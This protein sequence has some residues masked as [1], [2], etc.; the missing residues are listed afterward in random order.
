[1]FPVSKT[2]IEANISREAHHGKFEFRRIQEARSTS[3]RQG[4]AE[5]ETRAR[6]DV[7][8]EGWSQLGNFDTIY[9][10]IGVGEEKQIVLRARAE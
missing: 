6:Q 2:A 3:F 8:L 5:R 7:L 4:K 10:E 9:F 1:M